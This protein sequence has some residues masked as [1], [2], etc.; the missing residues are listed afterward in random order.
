[1]N[2]PVSPYPGSFAE[3]SALIDPLG[4]WWNGTSYN[5]NES[6]TVCPSRGYFFARAFAKWFFF[7]DRLKS[8]LSVKAFLYLQQCGSNFYS[9]LSV[10]WHPWG[11]TEAG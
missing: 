10:H 5:K 7:K 4:L 11:L 6:L 2:T 3:H 1:M 9:S 8:H